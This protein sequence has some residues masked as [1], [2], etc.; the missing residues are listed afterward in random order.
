MHSIRCSE[1]EMQLYIKLCIDIDLSPNCLKQLAHTPS[2][3]NQL[4]L[5]KCLLFDVTVSSEMADTRPSCYL[6]V[7]YLR[8]LLVV[9][10]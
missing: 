3:M 5:L 2:K 8:Y 4:K 9:L 6:L 7:I 10:N 1:H